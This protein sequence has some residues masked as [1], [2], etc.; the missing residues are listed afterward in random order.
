MPE[1][2]DRTFAA[3]FV[4]GLSEQDQRELDELPGWMFKPFVVYVDTG[5]QGQ[6]NKRS[7]PAD[8]KFLTATN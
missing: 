8:S 5:D 2:F 3:A 4:K 7:S 6:S 1:T